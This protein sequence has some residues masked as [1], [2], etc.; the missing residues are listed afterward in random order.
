MSN[1]ASA[2]CSSLLLTALGGGAHRFGAPL[3]ACYPSMR[4]TAGC[5]SGQWERTVNPSRKLRRFESF[6]C[7]HQR[8]QPLICG[9]PDLGLFVVSGDVRGNP[10]IYGCP[11]PICV[12][13]CS[14]AA[15]IRRL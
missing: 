13:D 1:D 11:C 8:K 14:S 5:P 9:N 6:T 12:Q 4:V 3:V 2:M 10:A 7:H 15:A